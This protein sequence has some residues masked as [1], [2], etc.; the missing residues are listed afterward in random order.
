M[1]RD[2]ITQEMMH[3]PGAAYVPYAD[4]AVPCAYMSC[5]WDFMRLMCPQIP[6]NDWLRVQVEL[7]RGPAVIV[8]SQSLKVDND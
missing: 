8:A 6:C 5:S 7:R 1:E 4:I 3:V 2:K